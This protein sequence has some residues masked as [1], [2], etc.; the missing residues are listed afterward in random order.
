MMSY[1]ATKGAQYKGC[2][3]QARYRDTQYR[4]VWWDLRWCRSI[5]DNIPARK[6]KIRR[7]RRNVYVYHKTLWLLPVSSVEVTEG[8]LRVHKSCWLDIWLLRN[9]GRGRNMYAE[10]RVKKGPYRIRKPSKSWVV[11]K[12][13]LRGKSESYTISC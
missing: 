4:K 13:H 1:V 9:K 11:Q 10:K 7:P 12:H 2:V 5:R 3:C 6:R 8:K